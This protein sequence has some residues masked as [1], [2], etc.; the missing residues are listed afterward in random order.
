MTSPIA[1][2]GWGGGRGLLKVKASCRESSDASISL[3]VHYS[4]VVLSFLASTQSAYQTEVCKA[5]RLTT[6]E[7]G[8]C[9]LLPESMPLTGL[10]NYHSVRF[11]KLYLISSVVPLLF[12]EL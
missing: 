2:G 8:S 11:I 6:D 10:L 1:D 7:I 9:R 3:A 4:I 5:Q 12:P